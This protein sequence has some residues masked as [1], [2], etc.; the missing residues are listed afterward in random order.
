MT[1]LRGINRKAEKKKQ[2]GRQKET[3]ILGQMSGDRHK[4]K[5]IVRVEGECV[6]V[7]ERKKS[8]QA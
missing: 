7:F 4:N 6:Y 1:G 8:L 3:I 5:E 2:N